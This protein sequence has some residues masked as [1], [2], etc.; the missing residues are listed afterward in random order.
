MGSTYERGVD[1]TTVSDEAHARNLV[2]LDLLSPAGAQRMRQQASTGQLLGWAG[3]RCA[4]LDRLPLAGALPDATATA[5]LL[6]QPPFHRRK[7]QLAEMPRLP[8]LFTLCALGSRGLTLASLCAE[9]LV[10]EAVSGPDEGEID[11]HLWATLDPARFLW[12]QLKRQPT[13]RAS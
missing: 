3:V 12:R 6:G 2:S 13:R 1:N 7:P 11:A 10:Q 8:G 9:R 5:A 4:S